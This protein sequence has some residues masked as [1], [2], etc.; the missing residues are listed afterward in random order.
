MR[1]R[2]AALL[3]GLAAAGLFGAAWGAYRSSASRDVRRTAKCIDLPPECTPVTTSNAAGFPRRNSLTL[4]ASQFIWSA[5][6]RPSNS[7]S[8]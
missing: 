6:G 1:T 8:Q 3:G 5:S 4:P 2:T 7:I